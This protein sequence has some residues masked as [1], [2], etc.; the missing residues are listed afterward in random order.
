[1]DTTHAGSATVYV[2]DSVYFSDIK[3]MMHVDLQRAINL[4]FYLSPQRL[5]EKDTLRFFSPTF[6]PPFSLVFFTWRL[7]ERLQY[8]HAYY[9]PFLSR[10]N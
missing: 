5:L 10:L 4:T 6:G 7:E 3:N 9:P 1:M 8:H 2:Y